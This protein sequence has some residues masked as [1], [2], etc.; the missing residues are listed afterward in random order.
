M[1]PRLFGAGLLA[2]AALVLL[3]AGVQ[4]APLN[5]HVVP[6]SHDDVGWLK[7]LD[8]YYYGSSNV[9]DNGSVQYILDSVVAAL[10]VD[11]T[12]KFIYVEQA[13]FSAWFLEQSDATKAVV[14]QLVNNGQLE[15]IN[16]GWCMHDEANTHY[17][18]MVDQT[19]L[20]HEFITQNF[21]GTFPTTGWQIDPFGHSATQASLLTYDLG[22]D[23]LFFKR[24]D[25][26]DVAARQAAKATEFVWRGSESAGASNQIFTSVFFDGYGMPDGFCFDIARCTD[27]PIM[28]DPRLEGF[29]L[30][31]RVADFIAVML[32]Q[33]AV[34]QGTE[35]L[36]LFGDDF[37]FQ[38]A[39]Q[40]FKNFELLMA[41]VNQNGTLN[42]F[43]STPRLYTLARNKEQMQRQQSEAAA[44]TE[45]EA[46]SV[47][48]VRSKLRSRTR[49]QKLRAAAAT[50]PA[51]GGISWPL[52][53]YSDF[54]P[55]S[56]DN[57]S[58][59]S[60]YFTSRPALKR[61][62]RR[63]SGLLHSARQLYFHAGRATS[64]AE[65]NPGLRRLREAVAVAQHHDAVAGTSMQH[66]ADDYT[67]RMDK[68]WT[69]T[70]GELQQFLPALLA[71]PNGGAAPPVG[72]EVC[73]Q[74]NI[75]VCAA[76][77]NAKGDL[78]VLLY[79]GLARNRTELVQVPLPAGS[80]APLYGWAVLDGDLQPV[81][82]QLLQ[83][84]LSA[85]GR[86]ANASSANSIV[87]LAQ[88]PAMGAA[89]Y[90]L[91]L[92]ICDAEQR[93]EPAAAAQ[94]PVAPA[95][96][97]NVVISN[98][99]LSLSF[100]PSTGLLTSATVLQALDGSEAELEP[101][102]RK[103][104]PLTMPLSQDFFM[105]RPIQ[106]EV[107]GK[108]DIQN[109]GAYIFRPNASVPLAPV[110]NSPSG[111]VTLSGLQT[112]PVTQQVTQVFSR[113]CHQTVRLVA[114][115]PFARFEWSVG[116]IPID[117]GW[118]GEVVTRYTSK[119]ASQATWLTDSNGREMQKRVRFQRPGYKLNI[120]EPVA[121][122]FYPVVTVASLSDTQ[123]EMAVL[124]DRA[125]GVTS[126]NDGQ[127]E[128]MVHRRLLA[129]DY[130]GVRE[131]LNETSFMSPYP[132][133]V[134]SGPGLSVT[135]SHQ[136]VLAPAGFGAAAA[137]HRPL[138]ARNHMALLEFFQ[139]LAP[140]GLTAQRYAKQFA[141]GFASMAPGTAL[142]VNVE[143]M[144]L[145][146]IVPSAPAAE[147]GVA[148]PSGNSVRMR[149][150]HQFGV[151]EHPTLSAPAVVDLSVLFAGRSIASITEM[152]LAGVR[153]LA[154]Q[155]ARLVWN[156]QGES[157]EERQRLEEQ[158]QDAHPPVKGTTVTLGPLQV[159]TFSITFADEAQAEETKVHLK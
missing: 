107:I 64:D 131:P 7:T 15:F 94:S 101:A 36:L 50:S 29:N 77:Q 90:F 106:N 104:V 14:R 132:D 20:G 91:R 23:S 154:E 61:F 24:I 25:H 147:S 73:P 40:M 44:T 117:E 105:Y 84:D 86:D 47:Q 89:S 128:F 159:R 4:A 119:I 96:A 30:Q 87:F 153:P 63:S 80:V 76:S 112:G 1:A 110:R 143:L 74:L 48:P 39:G 136:L 42:M 139:P 127:L 144:T 31:Q 99:Y 27:E 116:E 113:W 122:E 152:T 155:P 13:F 67:L 142:P 124:V 9:I 41:A 21:P 121:G 111:V 53:Q 18:D 43:Y 3:A 57:Y 79:N 16:G 123:A 98:E 33:A 54:F 151:H 102:Q 103:T 85:P 46:A 93:A 115:E 66:V 55:Y 140:V 137:V 88:V 95:A 145:E 129:D 72:L 150:A 146:S 52:K 135:G 82:S 133:P 32:K 125:Q 5:V 109:S 56:N 97:D 45:E 149:L 34:M 148:A 120:T 78:L 58:Y 92:E 60:G 10:Q 12:R 38:N 134:R 51:A 65:A 100:N 28:A 75:S 62:T 2:V 108:G 11:P 8:E 157:E 37:N 83:Q 49:R 71:R 138:A 158:R 35:L 156:V 22:F 81:A 141:S 59:W 17:V 6:H 118:G 130:R 70:A 26:Q 114:G 69:E 126:L 68:G 19:A